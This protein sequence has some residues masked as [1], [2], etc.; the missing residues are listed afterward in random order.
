MTFIN[1]HMTQTPKLPPKTTLPWRHNEYG[2]VSNHQPHDCLLNRLFRRRSKKTSKLCV[3]GLCAGNSPVTGE[4]P[5]QR[6]GNAENVSIW[7]RIM[8]FLDGWGTSDIHCAHVWKFPTSFIR[9]IM[10]ILWHLG[11]S[12][13]WNY[14]AVKVFR[15]RQS[16]TLWLSVALSMTSMNFIYVSAT[17]HKR[18]QYSLAIAYSYG[19]TNHSCNKT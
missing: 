11:F 2:G 3:T 14:M 7:W 13:R 8:N 17:K 9:C 12:T 18:K 10:P 4:F 19:D 5:A 6:A 15:Y 16:Q 1:L